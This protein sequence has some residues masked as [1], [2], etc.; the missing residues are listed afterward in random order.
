MFK[1]NKKISKKG[2]IF[3]RVHVDATWHSGHVAAPHGQ[4]R[5]LA[6]RG[7]DTWTHIYMYIYSV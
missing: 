6:W 3:A 7:G 4:A 1:S 5:A 2:L